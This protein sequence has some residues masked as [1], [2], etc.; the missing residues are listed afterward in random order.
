MK[1]YSTLGQTLVPWVL[2]T[3]VTSTTAALNGMEAVELRLESRLSWSETSR[4]PGRAAS[5]SRSPSPVT[6][7]SSS[8]PRRRRPRPEILALAPEGAG[9]GDGPVTLERSESVLLRVSRPGEHLLCLTSQTSLGRVELAASFVG[10]A[11]ATKERDEEEADSS[12]I[13]GGASS[14]AGGVVRDPARPAFWWASIGN[15]AKRR[16]IF[17]SNCMERPRSCWERRLPAGPG[18]EV[19]LKTRS[20]HAWAAPTSRLEAGAPSAIEGAGDRLRPTDVRTRHVHPM[21]PRAT[22]GKSSEGDCARVWHSG[23]VATTAWQRRATSVA[24]G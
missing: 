15:R 23:R 5:P 10:E 3:A 16:R 19:P 22:Q 20:V 11:I 9:E 7:G 2:L 24:V 17:S 1:T 8:S 12:L 13:R 14:A 6:C 18:D 21:N 4:D